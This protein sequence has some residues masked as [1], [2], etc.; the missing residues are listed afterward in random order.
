MRLLLP[1]FVI[2]RSKDGDI[3]PGRSWVCWH[4]DID[5]LWMYNA[6]TLIGLLRDICRN[7]KKDNSLVG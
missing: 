7:W 5:G 2:F 4:T 6:E 1:G 3:G